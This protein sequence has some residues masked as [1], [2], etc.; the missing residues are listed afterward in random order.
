MPIKRHNDRKISEVLNEFIH[1]NKRIQIQH[2]LK[3]IEDAW[4]SE[5]G[6]M[7]NGYTKRFY[8]KNGRLEVTLSSAPLRFEL[9]M[10]KQ[11]VIDIL[12]EKL[13]DTSIKE[14]V[15]K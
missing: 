10:S 11:K 3:R 7:I 4:R 14:I 12:N 6:D 5:M 1:K 2:D 8:F 15:L 13:G 9:N